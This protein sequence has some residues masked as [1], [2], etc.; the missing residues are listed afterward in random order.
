MS[1]GAVSASLIMDLARKEGVMT[2]IEMEFTD[3]PDMW[4][5]VRP[6]FL[7]SVAYGGSYRVIRNGKAV[8]SGSTGFK[9]HPF[10]AGVRDNLELEGYIKCERNY[11]NGDR[12]LRP[13]Y[14]NNILLEEGDPFS[15]AV[16]M[17]YRFGDEENHNYGEIKEGLLNYKKV[18]DDNI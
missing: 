18:D 8:K 13:F 2:Q 3:V 9:D 6:E 12:V 15:S 16:G 11:S 17:K 4:V 1:W 5:F 10:F 7:T 14:F